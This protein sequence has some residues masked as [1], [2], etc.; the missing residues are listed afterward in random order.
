MGEWGSLE[1]DMGC[2]CTKGEESAL[3]GQRAAERALEVHQQ[4]HCY[5]ATFQQG[6]SSLQGHVTC[7]QQE[8]ECPP[9]APYKAWLE[10]GHYLHSKRRRFS[11][12]R[13]QPQASPD[14]GNTNTQAKR[15]SLAQTTPEDHR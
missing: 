10:S 12:Q 7:R 9:I 11:R 14:R 2:R 6:I 3:T 15:T 5:I 4:E 1:R 13:H 8:I